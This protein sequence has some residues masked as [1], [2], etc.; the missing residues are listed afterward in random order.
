MIPA[1]RKWYRDL[2]VAEI[3]AETA[4]AMDPQ[5]PEVDEDLSRSSSR[6]ETDGVSMRMKHRWIGGLVLAIAVALGACAP[7]GQGGRSSVEPIPAAPLERRSGQAPE[8]TAPSE[9]TEA[10]QPAPSYDYDY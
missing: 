2:A 9:D 10:S 7:P 1:D 6:S 5:W 3:L 8:S 4:A